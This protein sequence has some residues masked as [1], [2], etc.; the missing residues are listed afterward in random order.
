[1]N[2]TQLI[3]VIADKAD[4]SKAQLKLPWNLPWLQLL[5]L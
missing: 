2:K 5:S 4:L 1:M 3:D